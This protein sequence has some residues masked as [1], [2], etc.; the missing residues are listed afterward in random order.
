M[1]AFTK[2]QLKES[3]SRSS[4]LRSREQEFEAVVAVAAVELLVAFVVGT[5][6]VGIAADIVVA[7]GSAGCGDLF[8]LHHHPC[9][10]A[11]DHLDIVVVG[12]L[13]IAA[14]GDSCCFHHHCWDSS[15][16][17]DEQQSWIHTEQRQG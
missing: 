12:L 6:V 11:V 15:D 3:R 2:Q 13:G 5:V 14:V 8:R 10:V 4:Q 16:G 9:A 7:A 1:F 17:Q